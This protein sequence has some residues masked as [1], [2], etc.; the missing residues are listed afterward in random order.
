[1]ASCLV[2]SALPFSSWSSITCSDFWWLVA[3]WVV[4]E[5]LLVTGWANGSHDMWNWSCVCGLWVCLLLAEP[6]V[7]TIC[8]VDLVCV[9][10][11]CARY[12]LSQRFTRHVKLILCVWSVCVVCECAC[13][14]LSQRFTRHVKL[15]LC[16]WSVSVCL[17]L[18]EP[19][20]H[21]TCEVDLVCVVCVCGLW[22]FAC[23]WLSQRFTRHVKLILCFFMLIK[24]CR[25]W[26]INICLLTCLNFINF[27]LYC[28]SQSSCWSAL[29]DV[30]VN[31]KVQLQVL[32][33]H[34]LPQPGCSGT[35]DG[36]G[37]REICFSYL[38]ACTVW[39]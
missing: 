22:V 25:L 15:I 12:W 6:T 2:D 38:S 14:W 39:H 8:E 33:S 26:R 18:A 10:C 13:Y 23:Y 21:T 35:N 9:V 3:V 1:M 30:K 19:T 37:T 16:V 7:H 34:S 31:I 24:L 17:L 29:F 36:L 5:C 4:C 27:E 20:V 11:E 28:D 32:C